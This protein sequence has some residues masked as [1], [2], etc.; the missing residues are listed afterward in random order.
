V[1][2]TRREFLRGGLA[3]AALASKAQAALAADPASPHT[4]WYTSE[5]KRWLEALPI[6]NGRVG[7]MVFGG[8]TKARIALTLMPSEPAFAWAH[9]NV[10]QR[11]HCPCRRYDHSH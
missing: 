4:L 7:G 11:F 6:G 8:I 2:P 1:K 3:L 5:A 9:A 10:R